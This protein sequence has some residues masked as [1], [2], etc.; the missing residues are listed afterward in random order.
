MILSYQS[1]GLK[2]SRQ[3]DII[4]GM[5]KPKLID[6]HTHIN[7]RDYK[8]DGDK[9]VRRAL[10]AGV[11][12][13]NSGS[14]YSTSKRAVEYANKH[15]EGV[16]AVVGLHPIHVLEGGREEKNWKGEIEERK[17]EELDERKYLKLLKDP[18]AVGVGE[19]GLEY[20]ENTTK[21]KKDKQKEIL[22][23][24]IEMAQQT[25]KPIVFHCRKAYDDLIELLNMFS[26]GCASCPM[27]CSPKLRG[28][29]HCFM[30][31]LSQAQKLTE[32]GFHLSFNG[33]ITYARDYDKVIK[34]IPLENIVLETDAPYLA[35]APHRGE[36]NE[37]AY[38]QYVAEKIAEIKGIVFNEVARRTTKNARELF[39][40]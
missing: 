31:K 36:K 38:V 12:I 8:D 2:T 17:Y 6:I 20:D 33:L 15:K 37:P 1:V 40:I 39:N 19:I 16:Y 5:S 14:Q 28:V 26:V 4:K 24:Q 3:S 13:I 21:D 25:N 30:G 11:W 18:K 27:A 9:V 34:S 29:I 35:P 10:E 22:I 32:M 7:F 23:R